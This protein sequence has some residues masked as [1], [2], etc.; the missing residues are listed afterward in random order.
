MG[1]VTNGHGNDETGG[2]DKRGKEGGDE[3]S[4]ENGSTRRENDGREGTSNGFHFTRNISR[5]STAVLRA[6][7]LENETAFFRQPLLRLVRDSRR[8][9]L[10]L[11]RPNSLNIDP[12]NRNRTSIERN[13]ITWLETRDDLDFGLIVRVAICESRY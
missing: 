6:D 3:G 1:T 12:L 7:S 2:N 11:R 13:L 10:F 5:A 8:D 9:P 4:S